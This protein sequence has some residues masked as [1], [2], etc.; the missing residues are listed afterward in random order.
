MRAAEKALL[1][2]KTDNGLG[3]FTVGKYSGRNEIAAR[4]VKNGVALDFFAACVA[5]ARQRVVELAAAYPE[6]IHSYRH[7]GW[8]LLHLACYHPAI[9][10]ALIRSG[11]CP[12]AFRKEMQNAPLHAPQPGTAGSRFESYWS[13]ERT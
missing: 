13:T 8:T 11:E 2:A 5:A 9:A 12:G 4:L 1:S 10:R 3:P 7:D 6:L